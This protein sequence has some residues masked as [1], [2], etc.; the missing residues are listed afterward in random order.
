VDVLAGTSFF[1]FDK[2]RLSR[3]A[4]GF[5]QKVGGASFN[6]VVEPTTAG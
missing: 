5:F 4:L 2:A 3:E 6:G 1:W